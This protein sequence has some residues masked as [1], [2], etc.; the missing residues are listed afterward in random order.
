MGVKFL[1][2]FR[3]Y[4]FHI[5]LSCGLFCLLLAIFIFAMQFHSFRKKKALLKLEFSTAF[6]L[7]AD[8]F[9]YAY[10]GN[11]S[12]AGFLITRVTNFVMFALTLANLYFLTEYTVATYMEAGKFKKLPKR[13]LVGFVLPC[14]GAT[15]LVISQ[16][17]GWY[18]S[19]DESNQYVRGPLFVVSYVIPA[20]AM[21]CLLTFIIQH[22]SKVRAGVYHSLVFY[23][24]V[25]FVAGLCQF[26]LYGL[27]LLNFGTWIAVVTIFW[28]A[29]KDQNIEMSKA[30][31]TEQATGLPNTYGYLYEVGKVIEQ[32]NILNYDGYYFDISRMGQINN[33]Y[34][35]DVGDEAILQFAYAVKKTL[36]AD[37]ILGRLGGNFFVAL[38]R[39]S[40]REKFLNLLSDVVVEVEFS[41]K[42]ET[43]HMSAVAGGYEIKRRNIQP[44]QIIGFCADAL[45]YAKHVAK[46]PY[47]F[48]DEA[49]QEKLVQK[50]LLE[51][52]IRKALA[53]GEFEPYYQPKVNTKINALHG[54]EALAR[55]KHDGIMISPAEFVPILEKNGGICK[56]DFW[57]LECV[58]RDL[59]DWLDLGM[60]PVTV[61]VNFSRRNLG[62]PNVAKEISDI[63]ERYQIPKQLIQV[64]ITET[65]DE[66]PI[67]ALAKFVDELHEYGLTA[68]I[69]DFGTGSSS[70]Y[71]LKEVSFDVLKIDK[72]LADYRSVRDKQLLKDV[73]HMAQD[74]DI[75]VLA[76]GIE[77]LEQVEELKKAGCYE[78]QG[79]VFDKPL[80]RAEFEKRLRL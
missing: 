75:D 23:C 2:G 64:E 29:L 60:E 13:L 73:I 54:A 32:R 41:E 18:Y 17:T 36:E 7:I 61:S 49:L 9:A 43:I 52:M 69:D 71:L 63:V 40:N 3:A 68:A 27:S 47:A 4:Q 37:E 11:M 50:Q 35:K 66:Y 8:A 80:V 78:I 5:L 74:L 44:G 62:N 46:Q 72:S 6:L 33:K 70:V 34:G 16:F 76:E 77:E 55:W 15:I 30:A 20:I 10:R 51:D 12:E 65:L 38:I 67:S 56:L 59:R 1:E 31:N 21:V 58:C 24:V 19:F 45:T 14:V 28:F 39:R 79:Y 53:D 57:I 26:F 48:L 42:K 25:P 22:R